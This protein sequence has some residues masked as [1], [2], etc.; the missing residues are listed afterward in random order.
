[1]LQ[2]VVSE[3]LRISPDDIAIE[4]WDSDQVPFD[5]GIAGSRATRVN[6]ATAHAAMQALKSELIGLVARTREWPEDSL[7]FINGEVRRP[8]IEEAIRW[9]VAVVEGGEVVRGRANVKDNERS[10]VTGFCAQVAEVA[11]DPETGEVTLLNFVTAHDVGQVIN[12]I[13]H[14]GQINGCIQ[15]G[16]GYALMEELKLE[17]GRVTTL[18][19]GDYKMPTMRDMPPFETVLLPASSG[20]GPYQIKGIGEAPTAPVAPA[21]TNAIADAVGV[22]LRSLPVSAEKVYW[23]LKGQP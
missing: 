23:E 18:S 6:T 12:P 1:M 7:T 5:S 16:L 14:Q 20:V 15:Q 11:V 10:H 22:R 8:D 17:D 13:A 21:I 4:V 9:Q 3:E 19:F 2:Q